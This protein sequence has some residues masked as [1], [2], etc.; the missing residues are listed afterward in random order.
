MNRQSFLPCIAVAAEGTIGVSYYDFRFNDRR[1][2]LPTDYWLVQCHPTRRAPATDPANWG[3]EVRLTQKSFDM[4]RA[5]APLF[6]YLLF[7]YESLSAVG[8]DFVTAFGQVDRDN[9]TGIFF[10]RVSR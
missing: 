5:W 3:D 4:E 6:E 9:I 8:N 7:G 1:P 2:G 10:R